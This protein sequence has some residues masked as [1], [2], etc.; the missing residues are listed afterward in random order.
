MNDADRQLID[1]VLTTAGTAGA[2]GWEYLVYWTRIDGILS[3][4]GFS[5][6][7]A[8]AMTCAI[9]CYRNYRKNQ[10]DPEIMIVVGICC[11]ASVA[12]ICGLETSIVQALAPEGY[13]LQHALGH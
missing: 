12:F 1:T 2:K 5:I 3:T 4:I 13:A 10:G 9:K 6:L 11:L 7:L 8:A